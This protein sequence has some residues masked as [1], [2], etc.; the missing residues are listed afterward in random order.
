V[1]VLQ[2]ATAFLPGRVSGPRRLAKLVVPATG[3]AYEAAGVALPD[4]PA[5]N[6]NM[7]D[8]DQSDNRHLDLPGDRQLARTAQFNA[9]NR[10]E[11]GRGHQGGQRE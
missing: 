1:S 4:G 3:T 9:A 5:K 11:P 2:W 6:F 8:Q 7:I 10:G